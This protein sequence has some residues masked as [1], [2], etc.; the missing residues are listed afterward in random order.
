[1]VKINNFVSKYNIDCRHIVLLFYTLSYHDNEPNKVLEKVLRDYLS[2]HNSNALSKDIKVID[3]NQGTIIFIYENY[4]IKGWVKDTKYS[5]KIPFKNEYQD[6]HPITKIN[7]NQ[8]MY[9]VLEKEFMER[10]RFN[11]GC[12]DFN[13]SV[14]RREKELNGEQSAGEEQAQ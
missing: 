2:K 4:V 13:N 5:L 11:E 12:E 3:F 7:I 14:I 6:V 10:L 1:M 8:S 9:E